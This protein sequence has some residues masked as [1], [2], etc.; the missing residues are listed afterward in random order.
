MDL[1]LLVLPALLMVAVL[2]EA[3]LAKLGGLGR[4]VV[5]KVEGVLLRRTG[6]ASFSKW[7]VARR[8]VGSPAAVAMSGVYVW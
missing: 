1:V 6:N 5:H 8:G 2:L 7:C 3:A 4:P